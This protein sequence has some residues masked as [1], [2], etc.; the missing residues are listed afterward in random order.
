MRTKPI[1]LCLLLPCLNCGPGEVAKE[2]E[3]AECVEKEDGMVQ[4]CEAI[5]EEQGSVCVERGCNGAT[6]V[7]GSVFDVC[8]DPGGGGAFDA[9]CESQIDW[10]FGTRVLCCCE[11]VP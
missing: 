3:L 6:Y 9:E 8:T 4:T 11:V 10:G 2:G 5:C 1:I 7:L